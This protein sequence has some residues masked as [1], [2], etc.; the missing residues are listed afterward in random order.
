MSGEVQSCRGPA[1]VPL[2]D[3]G[4]LG[5]HGAP[6]GFQGVVGGRQPQ[7]RTP[8]GAGPGYAAGEKKKKNFIVTI[9]NSC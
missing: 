5:I 4:R 8:G 3:G 7:R 9:V 2:Q 1:D 6:S